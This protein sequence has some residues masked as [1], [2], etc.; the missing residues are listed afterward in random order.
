MRRL[1]RIGIAVIVLAAV[2]CGL[3]WLVLKF[4][5]QPTGS[6][7]VRVF[8]AVKLK[9]QKTEYLSDE[10]QT[11]TCV[12]ALLPHGGNYPCWYLERH[13]EQWV[14]IDSGAA[15]PFQW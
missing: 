11:Q 14:D 1:K 9:G 4:R 15:H 7:Q 2:V 13:R 8:Y 6:V 3:D 10:P 12:N 5:K